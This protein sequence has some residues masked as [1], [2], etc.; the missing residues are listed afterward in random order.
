MLGGVTFINPASCTISEDS[1]IGLD[2]IIECNTHIR[3]KSKISNNCKIGPN[4]FIKDTIVNENCEIINSTI[5]NSKILDH[6]NIGPYSHVRPNC[7]ISSYS[8]IGNF[9]EIKNSHLD[10]QVKVN[11]LSYIGDSKIGRNTNI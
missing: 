9:V 1:I 11:H 4:S 3:G 5:F 8:K 6:V 7:E 10:K 2:V